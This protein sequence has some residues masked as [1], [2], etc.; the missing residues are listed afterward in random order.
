MNLFALNE[1]LVACRKP[2]PLTYSHVKKLGHPVEFHGF[3][4]IYGD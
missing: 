1:R 4:N 2:M 3:K